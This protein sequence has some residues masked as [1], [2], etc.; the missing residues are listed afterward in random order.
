MLFE[1]K[2][3]YA[4]TDKI[5]DFVNF[6]N[7]EVRIIVHCL[8]R[9][10]RE[11]I[12]ET[13]KRLVGKRYREGEYHFLQQNCQHFASYCVLGKEW[14]SDK[15]NLIEKGKVIGG[16]AAVVAAGAIIYAVFSESENYEQEK[17]KDDRKLASTSRR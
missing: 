5:E 15:D 17:E 1:K 10:S 2:K 8:R 4:K 3:A 7:Q 9:R 13:A 14:M 11:D 6:P 16:I 12:C